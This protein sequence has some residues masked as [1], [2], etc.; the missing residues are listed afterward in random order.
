[1]KRTAADVALKNCAP[2]RGF[3]L[4]ELLV[5]IAIIGVLVA[6]LLPAIQAAR[7]AA[8]RAQCQNSL[9]QIG[10]AVQN[11]HG[12]KNQLPPM[13]V[14]DH[15]QTWL[16]LILDYMEQTQVKGLWVASKG[17]FYDQSYQCRT[18]T[19]DAYYCPSQTHELR[20][21]EAVPDAV[22]SHNPV[23]PGTSR[24]WAGSISD[25]RAVAGSTLPVYDD[26]GALVTKFDD[27]TSQYVDGPIPACRRS[28]IKS[29]DAARRYLTGFKVE[30][31]LKHITDGT[32]NTLLAG[33]V[34]RG[35]SETGHAFNGDHTPGVF[36]GKTNGFCLRCGLPGIPPGITPTPAQQ[37]EYGDGNTFGSTHTGVVQ[38]VMCDGSVRSIGIDVDL[39]IMDFMATRAGG[40]VASLP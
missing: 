36:I 5:V 2:R 15:Q 11:Y 25:F 27:G 10:L 3:T 31:S 9:K 1:M 18:A 7:E 24:P 34:G 12:A 14:I 19:I 13:R 16:Q 20:F 33:E 30:T 23:D 38:F 40:E 4:V 39:G 37:L 21:V 26:A 32:S 8:R 28:N 6:L 29:T 22:H 35:T 17:C